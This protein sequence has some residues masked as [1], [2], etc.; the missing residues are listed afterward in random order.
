MPFVY[1]NFLLSLPPLYGGG[2]GAA[3]PCPRPSSQRVG[4]PPSASR[5]T[6]AAGFP[7]SGEPSPGW[8]RGEGHEGTWGIRSLSCPTFKA[9]VEEAILWNLSLRLA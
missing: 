2:N 1:T 4:G 5:D 7:S 3:H 8:G 6:P 9:G